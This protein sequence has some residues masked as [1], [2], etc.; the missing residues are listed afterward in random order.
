[1]ANQPQPNDPTGYAVNSRVLWSGGVATA[2]VAALVMLVGLLVVQELLDVAVV[3]T[4]DGLFGSQTVS[5][6]LYAAFAAL[7][8]TGLLH[9]LMLSTPR[10]RTFFA[11]IMGLL[12]VFFALL[13]LAV[14]TSWESRIGSGAIYLVVGIAV[15]SLLT[16]VG[17]SALRR[18]GGPR[19]RSA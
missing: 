2:V 1:V 19:R 15:T 11:W 16:G 12:T 8:A 5:L 9:L 13:P 17:Y 14:D 10:A 3:P 4:G 6:M 18:V 7:A